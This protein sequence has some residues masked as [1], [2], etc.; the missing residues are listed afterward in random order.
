MPDP[1]L[2]QTLTHYHVLERLGEGGMGVVYKA[3][4]MRLNRLVALKVLPPDKMADPSRRARFIQEAQAA[5]ALN[6]PNIVTVYEIDRDGA[7]DFLAME[8]IAGR[9][10]DAA[11]G[12]R[13]LKLTECLKYAIQ[14]ADAL[15]AA[16]AAGIVHR[17]LKPTNVMVTE[18]GAV[19]VL[20][21]GLAKLT[22]LA[23]PEQEATLTLKP[24]ARPLT[25]QG[26]VLGTVAY[27]SP[28]QA[29]GA[30]VDARSDIF[31]FGSLL[32]EMLT[33]RRAFHGDSKM[34]TITSILRDDP[35]LPADAGSPVPRDLE[36]ILTRC[37][38]KEPSRRFQHIDDVKVALE[39]LKEESDSG[40]LSLPSPPLPRRR[41]A[42]VA[43]VALFALVAV[44]AAGL[45]WRLRKPDNSAPGLTLRQLTQDTGTTIQPALSP[46]GKLVAYASDRAG[47]GGLDIWVQQLGRGSQAIRLTRNKADDF[48]PSFS[49]DGSQI[50]FSSGRDGGGIFVMPSL[51]GEE[52]PLLRGDYVFPR[53]SPDGRWIACNDTGGSRFHIVV[54]PV[55]GD[56]P[57]RIA[58]S[59]YRAQRPIWSPD[60]KKIL[61][62]GSQELGGQFDWWV[63]PL[64]GSPPV[65]T[66]APAV[67]AKPGFV[68]DWLDDYV[69]YTDG[70]LWRLPLSP[71]D[72]KAGK[73]ER[74][75]A[76]SAN[77]N[78]PRAISA[79]KPGA[80][81]IVFANTQSSAG[82]WSLSID[83]NAAKVLAEPVKL[84]HD[85]IDRTAPSLSAD[86]AR[87]GYVFRGLDGYGIRVRDT[88]TAA[89]TILLQSPGNLRARLSPDGSTVAYN[90][91][92]NE[93]ESVISLVSSSGGDSRKLCDTC[94]LVY[95]WSPD[96][97]KLVYRSGN[98]I[99]FSTIE[100]ATGRRTEILA[101]PKHSILAAMYSPD[102]LW[103]ALHY[104]PN[105]GPRG[106]FV[107]SV[108]D[109]RAAPE[110][111][112]IP[113]MNRPGSHTR[114]WWSP[115]GG[116][117]YFLST[118][119]GDTNIWAQRLDRATKRPLGDPFVIY[120]PSGERR[121]QTGPFFGP[122][123]GPNQIVFPLFESRGNIWLAE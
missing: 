10:L 47:D 117:L 82:L 37:L 23:S 39:E 81:K 5:S 123:L 32:Y 90:P 103:I 116:V 96:G 4:D 107:T 36:K 64:D 122:A 85:A 83:L 67:L 62:V 86:G 19:K 68:A 41:L 102:G 51:G 21:F 24:E 59:F 18:A 53:F 70:N 101:H 1:L 75:T 45:W 76:G 120:R 30:K 43:P 29:E 89:E 8:L 55:S 105:D 7:T 99:R 80:W 34:S 92:N 40:R 60:G 54:V 50:V 42:L 35:A 100:V 78:T 106:I 74:L 108:R 6:H 31:S 114:P 97:T 12:Q 25:E 20:D 22:E 58:E 121:T 3:R 27:M 71:S 17:D 119:E 93:K 44:L 16:H 33:G 69:L 113:L 65:R 56:A 72:F 2:G 15:T 26:A 84:I 94:G 28:E 52:R 38:R 57:R 77:E 49:P 88:R 61:F 98:P 48:L 118:A 111:E 9:T 110:N 63:A 73:P 14:I 11:I 13:G 109:G 115:D 112:W 66:G 91:T 104:A 95:D 87:L 46:D 79:G